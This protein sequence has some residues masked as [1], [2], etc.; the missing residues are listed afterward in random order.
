MGIV[1]LGMH[2]SGTSAVTELITKLG[3]SAG[4][5]KSMM[6]PTEAN[7]RGY[8]EDNNLAD[9]SDA[10]LEAVGAQ[11]YYPPVEYIED[12]PAFDQIR[13]DGK[14]IF[15]KTF[16][17]EPFVWKDPRL[18]LTLPI[19]RSII[20]KIDLAV[21]AVR[22]PRQIATSL[23][24]RGDMTDDASAYALWEVYLSHALH[25]L[26]DLPVLI[27]PYDSLVADPQG[28]T[29]TLT[30]LLTKLEIT[31]EPIST[32]ASTV[33]DYQLRRSDRSGLELSASQLDLYNFLKQSE[34]FHPS[35]EAG[36]S[37]GISVPTKQILGLR[38]WFGSL[39]LD[40]L[41]KALTPFG[42]ISPSDPDAELPLQ[43]S[44][45]HLAEAFHHLDANSKDLESHIQNLD[46][47]VSELGDT[48]NLLVKEKDE[49]VQQ[50]NEIRSKAALDLMEATDRIAQIKR[51]RGAALGR[52]AELEQ[53][54][55]THRRNEE[56]WELVCAN[57]AQSLTELDAIK[58]HKIL[59]LERAL[60]SPT[61]LAAGIRRRL[62]RMVRGLAI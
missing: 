45:T 5:R 49:L 56:S 23:R 33:I 48:A 44:A 52:V 35:F 27:V 20:P 4:K 28:T 62:A 38:E 37:V 31:H 8:F 17:T 32:D 14:D 55:A 12:G 26:R 36:D 6:R 19:A 40:D 13:M 2:R 46:S 22:D 3:F 7:P 47:L 25:N 15:H 10:V 51:E 54:V 43:A 9:Y 29:Q 21:L 53:M 1:V 58:A 41:P 24:W 39:T 61:L 18:C 11:S 57:F 50:C 16:G 34:G 30:D 59:R 42:P 60:R